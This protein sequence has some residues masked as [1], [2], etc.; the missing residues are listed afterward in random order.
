MA[1][2]QNSQPANDFPPRTREPGARVGV[3]RAFANLP[4]SFRARLSPA[5]T[6][7]NLLVAFLV[8]AVTALPATPAGVPFWVARGVHGPSRIRG[9]VDHK[10]VPRLGGVAVC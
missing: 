7:Q 10:P 6:L 5:G 8:S 1:D 9:G 4:R 2:S 3:C